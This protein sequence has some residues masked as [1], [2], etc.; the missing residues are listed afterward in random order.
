M[1][2]WIWIGLIVL[3]ILGVLSI[4][5]DDEID[6][7]RLI[8]ANNLPP[9]IIAPYA[10]FSSENLSNIALTYGE[11]A[12]DAIKRMRE[13][14]KQHG[15]VSFYDIGCGTGK[16]LLLAILLGFERAVGVE[17]VKRR[18]DIAMKMKRRLPSHLGK[19]LT[20]LHGDFED[21]HLVLRGANPVMVFASN[22]MWKDE[23]NRRLFR[24]LN[25]NFPRGSIVV[26]SSTPDNKKDLEG[27]NF[28]ESVHM[29]MSWF[30]FS[31]CTV[32]KK[33]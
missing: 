14:A 24:H 20:I 4:I 25:M 6:S 21:P 16:A 11:V 10:G 5:F 27:F 30:Y 33:I 7:K 22:V 1:S 13:I 32:L 9:D 18:Y 12:H 28:I 2:K 17:L 23:D 26:V 19:R 15:I 29:P 3:G 31:Y 8:K